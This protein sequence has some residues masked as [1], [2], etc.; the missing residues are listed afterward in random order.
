MCG[1]VGIVRPRA[2]PVDPAVLD[3][4]SAAIHHRGP[5]GAGSYVSGAVGL[6]SRRLSILDLSALGDQPMFSPDGQVV[7]VFNGE[8]Y[9]YIELRN[10]LQASGHVFR[11][12]GD[13]EVFLHAY[14]Q[15]GRECLNRLNGMWAFLIYDL[16]RQTVFGSRDR[17]GKK[18]LYYYRSGEDVLFGSEI[19]AILAS[20]YYTSRKNWAKISELFLGIG[21]ENQVDDEHTFYSGIDQLPAGHAFELD[22]DGKFNQWRYWSPLNDE[23]TFP[24]CAAGEPPSTFYE[25]FNSACSL[26]IRSDVPVGV[27]LSGGIDSVSVLCCLAGLRNDKHG[28]NN[29]SAFSYQAEEYDESSYINDAIK[30]TGAQLIQYTPEP[31]KLWNSL[32]AMLWHQDEP[33]HSMAAVLTFEM[34]RLASQRGIKVIL[35]GG[36]TDEYLA[37]YP[38]F[39]QNYWCTL[40]GTGKVRR[41]W[42][43]IRAHCAVRGSNPRSLFRATLRYLCKSEL[44]R[45]PAYQELARWNRRR[46]SRKHPWFTP[47]LFRCLPNERQDYLE[48]SLNYALQRAVTHAPLPVYL[49]IDDRNSMAHSVEARAPFLD[50]RLVE[51]VFQ[52]PAHW[53]MRGP[54]TKYLLR[55]AMRHRIP[56]SVRDRVEKWGFPVPAKQWFARELSEPVEDL[57]QS[58]AARERGIYNLDRIRKDY[59]LHKRGL[60]DISGKLFDVVQF[61]LWCNLGAGG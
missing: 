55:E 54:L 12:S 52:Q 33:V 13:T 2:V 37:G 28:P 39:F 19:K 53:K 57:L 6:A 45:V 42:K 1:F 60:I 61:E 34:Y 44:R 31:R 14:L 18:P 49:R 41:A 23:R 25:I 43:E 48:P 16:R 20:G 4:M 47:D 21:L 8:I 50:F 59:A 22:L 40:L 46:E 27:L 17:V 5:D 10:E 35:H 51:M 15:W 38:V 24:V 7:L 32:E 3:R 58:Q 29:L 26:R 36:G 56:E 9:N 30:Q 11:S